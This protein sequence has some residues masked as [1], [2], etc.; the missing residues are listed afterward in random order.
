MARIWRSSK[1]SPARRSFAAANRFVKMPRRPPRWR[2]RRRPRPPR[3]RRRPRHRSPRGSRPAPGRPSSGLH[4]GH[5]VEGWRL[6][7]AGEDLESPRDGRVCSLSGLRSG[8]AAS[9]ASGARRIAAARSRLGRIREERL[10]K[11]AAAELGVDRDHDPAQAGDVVAGDG[12][13]A[14]GVAAGEELLERVFEGL[15]GGAVGLGRVEDPEPRVDPDRD[16]VRGEQPVAEAMDRHHPGAAEAVEQ[17]PRPVRAGVGAELDRRPDPLP[18]L[19]GGLVGEGEGEDRVGRDAL[20]ADEAA[21]AVDHDAR[22]CRSR[23]RPRPGRR[24]PAAEIADSCSGVGRRSPLIALRLLPSRGP[25]GRRS[26]RQIGAKSQ[27]AGQ[28][29]CPRRPSAGPGSRRMSTSPHPVDDHPCPAAGV[30]DQLLEVRL[31]RPVVPKPGSSRAPRPA[32]RGPR[33]AAAASGSRAAG[34]RG[35]RSPPRPRARRRRSCRAAAAASPSPRA[36][37]GG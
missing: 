34:G 32:R 24:R 25:R 4:G 22:S 31:R 9:A 28:M 17:S 35:R 10:G 21:V 3:R 30:L 26:R 2:R 8:S 15:V 14:L 18:E 37:C 1:S 20:V 27:K 12:L 36:A 5:Q 11:P 19:G 16:R 13:L 7:G 29:P 6:G 33:R 23:R